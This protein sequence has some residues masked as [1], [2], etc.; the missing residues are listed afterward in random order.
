[1]G[2]STNKEQGSYMQL[3][4]D[5]GCCE[6]FVKIYNYNVEILYRE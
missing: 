4:A 3:D 2:I 1:M 6:T 5:H